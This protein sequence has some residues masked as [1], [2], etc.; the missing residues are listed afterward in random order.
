[1]TKK[2]TGTPGATKDQMIEWAVNLY[3]SLP[4]IRM[5][6]KAPE[7]GRI[8]GK[9]EHIADAIGVLHAGAASISDR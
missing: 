9:N 2:I 1:M 5:K 6:R 3:P 7:P 8:L 4:W